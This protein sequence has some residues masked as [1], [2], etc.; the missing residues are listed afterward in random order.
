MNDDDDNH[1]SLTLSI[2]FFSP[3]CG[4]GHHLGTYSF[5]VSPFL[6]TLLDFGM[7][8][9]TGISPAGYKILITWTF[10]FCRRHFSSCILDLL[11][12][13]ATTSPHSFP[14]PPCLALNFGKRLRDR[15]GL[16]FGAR[17]ISG[18]YTQLWA[19]ASTNENAHSD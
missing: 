16:L 15:S 13:L 7:C 11:F 3:L 17:L 10:W 4:M 8:V 9:C 18:S 12:A 2:L 6:Q 14:S 19:W 1:V 5:Q